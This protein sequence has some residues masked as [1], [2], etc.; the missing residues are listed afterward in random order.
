ML[1]RLYRRAA[2][3]PRFHY[4]SDDDLV[5][6]SLDGEETVLARCANPFLANLFAF[7]LNSRS[8]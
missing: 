3:T 4:R 8:S 7:Q 1:K 6:R 5:I 2:R